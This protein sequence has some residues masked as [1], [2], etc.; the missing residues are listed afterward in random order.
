MSEE[1]FCPECYKVFSSKS[2]Y[3]LIKILGR[4]KKSLSVGQLTKKLKLTQ[5]TVSH[6]LQV[7]DSAD[8]LFCER[9]GN[10]RMYRLNKEA[11][12]FHD[13]HISFT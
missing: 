6:H 2:R 8:A 12:C 13:C 10:H 5:P 11:H 7:L 1:E 4:S 9:D 3:E